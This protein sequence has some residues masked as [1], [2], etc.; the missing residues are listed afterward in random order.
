MNRVIIVGPSGK[1]GANSFINKF[2]NINRIDGFQVDWF[3]DKNDK[4]PTNIF[5]KIITQ[6]KVLYRLI[7]KN[8]NGRYNFGFLVCNNS[9]LSFFKSFL[10][11]IILKITTSNLIVRFGGSTQQT[12]FTKNY[13]YPVFRYFFAIQTL[14]L[15]QSKSLSSVFLPYI[16]FNG[17]FMILPNFVEKKKVVLNPRKIKGKIEVLFIGG[18]DFKRKGFSTIIK[19]IKMSQKYKINFTGIGTPKSLHYIQD[20]FNNLVLLPHINKVKV[21]EIISKSDILLLPSKREGFPNIVVEAMSKGLAILSS[22]AG[23]LKDL[24]KDSYNGFVFHCNDYSS[25]FSKLIFLTEN[26]KFYSEISMNN[27]LTVKSK[28]TQSKIFK[29][30]ISNINNLDNYE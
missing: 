14:S 26:P 15:F 19:V 8:K 23:A 12:F 9:G 29:S 21:E 28:Y 20:K 6:W 7:I 30:F 1:G 11:A 3:V 24:I 16:S 17:K 18:P 2:L 10:L 22:D 4:E 5:H 27:L 13:L 25:F